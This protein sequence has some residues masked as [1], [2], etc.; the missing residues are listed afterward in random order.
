ME[1]LGTVTFRP[2][3]IVY[4]DLSLISITRAVDIS[5]LD[6]ARLNVRYHRHANHRDAR[7]G[8]LVETLT[9]VGYPKLLRVRPVAP[10]QTVV[11][12]PRRQDE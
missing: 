5:M 4:E 6:D 2:E 12:T 8:V 9:Q 7:I 3:G 10:Q 1:R 11:D